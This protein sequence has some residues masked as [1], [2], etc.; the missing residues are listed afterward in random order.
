MDIGIFDFY[1]LSIT[2]TATNLLSGRFTADELKKKLIP[3]AN[4]IPFPKPDDKAG[5]STADPKMLA[6]IL[7]EAESYLNYEWPSIPATKSLLFERTGDRNEYQSLSFKKRGVLGV[8]LLAEVHE[9][10]GRFLDAIIDGVW[11]I[12][13]ESFWGVPRICRKQRSMRG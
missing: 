5:W 6:A 10:K 8:L 1:L 12:C 4:W 11:S 3:Q 2:S 7:K 9:N 13:E